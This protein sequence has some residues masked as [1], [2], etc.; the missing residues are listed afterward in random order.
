MPGGGFDEGDV[1]VAEEA[2]TA[3]VGPWQRCFACGA[4]GKWRKCGGEFFYLL[5]WCGCCKQF[6]LNPRLV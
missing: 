1:D 4:V 6:F 5:S 3:R 2:K